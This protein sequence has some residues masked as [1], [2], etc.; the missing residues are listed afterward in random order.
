MLVKAYSKGERVMLA[1]R[2]FSE[3]RGHIGEEEECGEG[4]G[5][6]KRNILHALL[7]QIHVD[8]RS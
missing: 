1:L 2:V 7:T 6:S 4:E 5:R 8:V 3:M